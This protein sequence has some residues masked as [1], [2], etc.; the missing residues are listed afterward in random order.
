MTRKITKIKT[1]LLSSMALLAAS[2]LGASLFAGS[3]AQSA[4]PLEATQIETVVKSYILENPEI[5]VEAL[6][7]Y[8]KNKA[9]DTMAALL[10]SLLNEKNGFIAGAKGNKAKVV[11]V[12]LFD[13]HCGYCKQA[14]LFV[15]DLIETEKDVQVVFRELPILREEST[16]AA[17]ISLAS[18][19][20]GKYRDLHLALMDASG[21]LTEDRI[22]KIAKNTGVNLSTLYKVHKNTS[23]KEALD[24]T[25]NIAIE[26]GVNG[27]P[28]FIIASLDGSF[29]RVIPAWAPEDVRAAI[30]EARQAG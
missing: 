8:E 5:I 3:A 14:S 25:R 26:L 20:Q 29:S 6:E 18:R 23:F 16:Y 4:S 13:Y 30:R 22:E 15:N 9:R 27:T 19:G 17:E 28:T 2:T 10:P 7:L 12:E 21:V 24:E 11:V 1:V